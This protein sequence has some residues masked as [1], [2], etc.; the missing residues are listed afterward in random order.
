MPGKHALLSASASHRWLACP[1]SAKLCA[2]LPDS[3]S[4]FAQQ[5]TDAHSLCEYKLHKALGHEAK[6]PTEDLTFFDEEMADCSDMYNGPPVKTTIL[7]FLR[8]PWH[9]NLISKNVRSLPG[10]GLFSSPHTSGNK[11]R[12]FPLTYFQRCETMAAPQ[13]LPYAAKMP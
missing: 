4:S 13:P 5:G 8:A 12:W 3:S 2:E 7:N 11:S 9:V 6:D 1:P 10:L